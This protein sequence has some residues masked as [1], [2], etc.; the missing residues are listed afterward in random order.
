M[1]DVTI[2]DGQILTTGLTEVS[3]YDAKQNRWMAAAGDIMEDINVVKGTANTTCNL[4]QDAMY[5][6]STTQVFFFCCARFC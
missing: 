4:L 3:N 2:T 1:A 5:Y 6:C